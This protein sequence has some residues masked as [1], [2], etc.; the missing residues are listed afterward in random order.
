MKRALFRLLALQVPVFVTDGGSPESFVAWLKSLPNFTVEQGG[1]GLV[2]QIRTSLRRAMEKAEW[3]LYTEPDKAEFFE[4]GIQG[5]IGQRTVHPDAQLLLP[6]R[7]EASFATFPAGQRTVEQ[8]F[9]G[10]LANLLGAAPTDTL[11]GPLLLHRSRLTELHNIPD[12]DGW[13]W[14]IAVYTSALRDQAPIAAY[15][16]DFACPD[17]QRGEDDPAS[18]AY[19]VKQLQQNIRALQR[20]LE[21][22]A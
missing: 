7:S 19:R 14:R 18:R 3:I 8:A 13:G 2:P 1:G 11:Y 16:G 6:T 5:L 17:D 22:L 10:M 4:N 12:D 21:R 9:N 15:Q 20:A